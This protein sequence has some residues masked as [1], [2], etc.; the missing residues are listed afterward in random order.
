MQ[1][2]TTTDNYY[3]WKR[4][5][6][7]NCFRGNETLLHIEIFH[8]FWKG[9]PEQQLTIDVLENTFFH[10]FTKNSNSINL[11]WNDDGSRGGPHR[12]RVSTC[13]RSLCVVCSGDVC[14]VVV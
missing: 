2:R 14:A 12:V 4:N 6:N 10:S 1:T 13:D 5:R 8:T 3:L 11:N 7:A 9:D